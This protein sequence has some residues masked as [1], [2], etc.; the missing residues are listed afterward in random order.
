MEIRNPLLVLYLEVDY[1]SCLALL[2]GVSRGYREHG[3][4]DES[5]LYD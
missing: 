2:A 1:H 3:S 5:A 4:V